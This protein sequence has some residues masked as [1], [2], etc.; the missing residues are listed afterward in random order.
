[1]SYRILN[2]KEY[3]FIFENY[4]GNSPMEM[5]EL[6]NNKFKKNFSVMQIKN[7][8]GRHHLNSGKTGYFTAGH[9]PH[10]KGKKL[11]EYLSPELIKKIKVSQFK[12]GNIPKNHKEIYSERITKDGYIEVK[13][14]E[15]NVWKLKHRYVWEQA[16]GKVPKGSV[17]RFLDGN[18][19]NCN[20]DNLVL[21]SRKE[22]IETIRNGFVSEN[23]E[24]TKAVINIAK[25]NVAVKEADGE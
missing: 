21:I 4:K 11:C 2:D 25:L 20:I 10:N 6:L 8:Y 3:N 17:I 7:F 13:I 5:A 1:M 23:P 24:I 12:K 18:K 15:P 19:Q 14:A 16:H 9:K 22:H